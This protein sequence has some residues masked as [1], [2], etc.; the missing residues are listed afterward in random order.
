MFV[1]VG[2][3]I[4]VSL[5][6]LLLGESFLGQSWANASYD[7]LF[8]FG[9]RPVTNSVVLILM[10]NASFDQFH[11]IRGQPWDRGL[12]AQLLNKLADDHCRMVVMDSFFREPKDATKD[13]A[14]A[15]AMKRLNM[16]LMAEQ[17]Q[18]EDSGFTGAQPILPCEPFLSAAKTNWGVAWL[19][20]DLDSVIRRHWPFPSPGPYPSMAETAAKLAGAQ[21]NPQP[22]ARWLRYYGQ[23][24]AWT[25]LSYGFAL[26]Q[27]RDF[28]RDKIIF[29]GTQP[30]T[31]L[32]DNEVDEFK[33]P[34][35]RW[36]DEASGGVEIIIT[37]FLNLM[38]HDWMNRPAPWIEFMIFIAGGIFWGAGLCGMRIQVAC[39]GGIA[40]ML[41]VTL[42][43]VSTS[44]ATNVWFPWL[45]MA[46]GQIPCALAWAFVA[47]KISGADTV[48]VK[49]NKILQR[50]KI[51]G[52]KL[53]HPPFG[54]GAYGRVWLARKAGGEWCALK[55]IYRS[56]FAEDSVA[57]ERE[58]EG[59]NTYKAL[60]GEH[61]GLLRVDLVSGEAN[62]FFYYTMELGDSLEP[63]WEK[64]PAQ[65]KPCDLAGECS[66]SVNRR[67]SILRSV[68]IGLALTEAL[69]FLHQQGLTHRDIK[70]PNIIFVKGEPKL[71]DFGLVRKMRPAD[72]I[73]TMIGTPG[74][75]PPLPE[76]PGTFQADIFALG[77]VLYVISTGREAA[78]FPEIATNLMETGTAAD[79]LSLNA[80]IL[81]ACNVR[82]DCR[83]ASASEMHQALR[84]LNERL[85]A[86]E[87]QAG[88][89]N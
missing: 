10:D 16:V 42:A 64:K 54:E 82:L 89:E 17:A 62:G 66:R 20:P 1:F 5:C 7:Y 35:T 45:A 72:E 88:N 71:A 51:S 11:Q 48:A 69:D 73:K 50:P 60:S 32:P 19:D 61:P 44:Y 84:Q 68:R 38:N 75:M 18:V 36:T 28:F 29:I 6:G 76:P 57:Y 56:N 59:V 26:T 39:F 81:K 27:P 8:R 31:V 70:P 67:L 22:Q 41:L 40:G 77:M 74:Y 4:L 9:S 13:D 79:F 80:I 63:A 52:Y 21:L 25:K 85:E 49:G 87:S 58:F 2:G 55:V 23:N 43:A 30:Q 83:Y 15:A 33:T 78:L 46:G 12:H 34:F 37:Q 65:Y 14:L 3:A 47:Q 86:G 53:F 24:G